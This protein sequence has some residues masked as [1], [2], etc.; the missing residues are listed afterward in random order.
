ME[1][2]NINQPIEIVKNIVQRSAHPKFPVNDGSFDNIIGILTAKRF[3]EYLAENK[4]EPLRNVLQQPIYIP[5]T[6]LASAVLNIF[7]KQKQYLGIVIDEYGSIEG[8]VTLHD[9][10]E[11]TVGDLPD[12]DELDEPGIV[13]REVGSLLV[14]GSTEIYDLNRELKQEVIP[15]D[16]DNYLTLAGFISYTFGKLPAAGDK[17]Q[18]SGYEVEIVDM[19]GFRVTR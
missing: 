10:L 11:A 7:K 4:G 3:Y 15:M 18:V 5:V 14:N 8:I 12:V 1:Y 2:V 19:D 9:I 16:A 6:M 13:K 17:L